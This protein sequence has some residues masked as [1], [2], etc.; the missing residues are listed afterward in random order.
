MYESANKFVKNDEKLVNTTVN[1]AVADTL[2][3]GKPISSHIGVSIVPPP[4]PSNPPTNPAYA[5]LKYDI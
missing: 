1:V 5:A 4:R 3:L 2:A